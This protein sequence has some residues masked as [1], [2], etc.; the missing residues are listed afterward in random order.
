MCLV[1]YTVD[2]L[3]CR[4]QFTHERSNYL[5]P[6]KHELSPLI[7]DGVG[8]TIGKIVIQSSGLVYLDYRRLFDVSSNWICALCVLQDQAEVIFYLLTILEIK[9]SWLL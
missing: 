6:I 8:H 9:T 5:I 1:F 7:L 2:H 4:V 3:T